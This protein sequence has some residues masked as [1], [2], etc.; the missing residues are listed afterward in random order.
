M[1]ARARLLTHHR[2]LH[3][4]R[5]ARLANV[6]HERELRAEFRGPDEEVPDA[7]RLGDETRTGR[8]DDPN[9]DTFDT[10]LPRA[11]RKHGPGDREGRARRRAALR[12]ARHARLSRAVVLALGNGRHLRSLGFDSL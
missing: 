6:H 2:G 9:L 4:A 1:A 5:D 8:I 12:V 11:L 7:V 10:N 3:Q